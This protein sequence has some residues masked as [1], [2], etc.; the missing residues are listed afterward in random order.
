MRQKR[1][2]HEKRKLYRGANCLDGGSPALLCAFS[3]IFPAFSRERC[4]Y[5]RDFAEISKDQRP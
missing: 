3:E 4:G 1:G 5:V 2:N